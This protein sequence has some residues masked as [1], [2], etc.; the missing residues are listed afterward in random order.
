M[1][2]NR[3]NALNL[4][5]LAEEARHL[6]EEIED[7]IYNLDRYIDTEVKNPYKIYANYIN[8]FLNHYQDLR[9]RIKQVLPEI[10]N[11]IMDIESIHSRDIITEITIRVIS[12]KGEMVAKLKSIASASRAIA[13]ALELFLGPRLNPQE[14][15]RLASLRTQIKEVRDFDLNLYKHLVQAIDEYEKGHYLASSLISGKVVQYVYEKLCSMLNAFEVKNNKKICNVELVAKRLIKILGIKTE[16]LK[17]LIE[18]SKLA[19]N[20]FTHDV[21][22]IPEPHETLRLLSGACDLA[23]KYYALSKKL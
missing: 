20:Y 16:Y 3:I 7:F 6:G 10:E 9:E 1:T 4:R 14:Y 12:S 8:I 5:I 13:D 15:D 11:S 19:R 21:N 22:A 17:G 23:L 2:R 18:T